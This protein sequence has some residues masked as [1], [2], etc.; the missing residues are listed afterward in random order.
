MATVAQEF[1]HLKVSVVAPK[2]ALQPLLGDSEGSFSWA[3]Q[4]GEFR[5]HRRSM[6][7]GSYCT[8]TNT[9]L[10]FLTVDVIGMEVTFYDLM[11][12]IP[13]GSQCSGA[14]CTA[15]GVAGK[16]RAIEVI[17]SSSRRHTF[18]VSTLLCDLRILSGDVL[19]IF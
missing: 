4:V 19:I 14:H 10:I 3:L 16:N 12:M 6:H 8:L 17:T 7:N 18:L 5:S 9:L 2:A 1:L 15:S 13:E 11:L